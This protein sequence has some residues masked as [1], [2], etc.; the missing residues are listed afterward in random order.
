MPDPILLSDYHYELPQARIAQRPAEPRDAARLLCYRQGEISHHIFRQLD[1][2]LPPGS[3]LVFNDTRVIPARLYFR[4][5]SGA[6]IELLLLHPLDP[7]E[8]HRAMA[9]EGNTSWE[10]MVG[11]KKKWKAGETLR[12]RLPLADTEIEISAQWLDRERNHVQFTWEPAGVSFAEL[13]GAAGELP[14]PPYLGREADTEDRERYQTV[15]ARHEGAVAAPTA[16]LHFTAEVLEALEARGIG[17][18]FVTLHVGAGTFMPIKTNDATAHDMHI[19]Q[20]LFGTELLE[21]LIRHE[22]PLIPVGTT[23]MRVLESL[24]WFGLEAMQAGELPA[25]HAFRLEAQQAYRQAPATLP[26]PKAALQALL[27]HMQQHKL[28]RLCAETAIYI[29]PGYPFRLCQGLVTNFHLPETTLMLLVAAL[30]GPDWRRVYQTAL[31]EGYRFLSYGDS[32]L[33]LPQ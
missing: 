32:S 12:S 22:G 2:L 21:Q 28:H 10:L 11:N 3:L 24:Y 33:L 19:E 20:L 23:S 8:V 16:G 13:I 29:Y 17:R 5:E 25:E 30:L 31:D 18:A 26:P 15:Y 9:A 14:L 7:A 6:L 27:K 1:T 4:R